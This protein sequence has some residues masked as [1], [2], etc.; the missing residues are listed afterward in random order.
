V[1]DVGGNILGKGLMRLSSVEL[2]EAIGSHTSV[3]GGEVIHRDDLVVF[4]AK[5]R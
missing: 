1:A 4:V 5:P 3:I 2:T